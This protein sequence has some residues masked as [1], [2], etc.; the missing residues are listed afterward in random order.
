QLDADASACR[1][2]LLQ[3]L[4][5]F[6]ASPYPDVQERAFIGQ[7]LVNL[8]YST[9]N[10]TV[11]EALFGPEFEPV[12]G[13][14]Q[15]RVALP[16][17][18]EAVLPTETVG[19][20]LDS[21]ILDPEVAKW[22]P[23]SVTDDADM[24]FLQPYIDNGDLT[25]TADVRGRD[26][27]S[28]DMSDSEG[29]GR[30]VTMSTSSKPSRRG[31]DPYML[32]KQAIPSTTMLE[33][34][35][36]EEEREEEVAEEEGDTF[37]ELRRRRKGRHGGHRVHR[38]TTHTTAIRS[39]EDEDEEEEDEVEG[40]RERLANIDITEEP[41]AAVPEKKHKKHRKRHSEKP[42]EGKKEERRHRHK[43]S[44]HKKKEKPAP[45]P[46]AKPAE[47]LIDFF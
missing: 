19:F 30:N 34:A 25:G 24:E 6:T 1:D 12:S 27:E 35:D 11:L 36:K 42:S 16:T 20:T 23:F 26:E 7:Q 5:D 45:A 39:I 31:E 22:M 13:K 47:G 17:V 37:N 9:N 3:R 28:S 43:K 44:S 38:V 10:P 41:A 15:K 21:C 18:A 14:A 40:V 46:E 4:P 2:A 32:G 29:L 8:F 33:H